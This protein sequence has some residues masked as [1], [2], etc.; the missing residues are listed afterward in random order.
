MKLLIDLGNSRL[1]WR[2]AGRADAAVAAVGHRGQRAADLVSALPEPL[3]P[4]AEIRIASVAGPELTVDLAAA[5]RARFG[6]VPR[7]AAA[8]MTAGRLRNGYRDPQQLGVDRWLAMRAALAE[9]PPIALC[10]VAAGTAFTLDL[11][12]AGG[13]HAGGLI[14]PGLGL[15]EQALRGGTGNLARLAGADPA[16]AG[17]GNGPLGL[18]VARATGE[19]MERGAAWALAALAMHHFQRLQA[20]APGARLLVTGGDA[21]R[22]APL[23]PAVA[24]YRPDLV[25]EGLALDP[26]PDQP[27]P[28]LSR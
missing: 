9:D 16:P 4:V 15:M 17:D 28:A 14:V 8:A 20:H 21:P 5:L 24:D 1:K 7:I 26:F 3:A 2:W 10:I 11:L 19:A 6:L 13:Q 27:A 25:L 12:D 23:L 22:L 18:L